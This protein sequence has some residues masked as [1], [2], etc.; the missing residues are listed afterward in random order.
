V[1]IFKCLD[2]GEMVGSKICMSKGV[3]L[4]NMLFSVV[5]FAPTWW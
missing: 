5:Y 3:D 1:R 2:H 4:N